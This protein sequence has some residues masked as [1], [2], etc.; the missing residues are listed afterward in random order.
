M[1]DLHFV[2]LIALMTLTTVVTRSFFFMLG[3]ARRMPGWLQKSLG[4]VPAVAL[5][6]ILA[7]DLLLSG[8]VL[9]EPWQNIRLLAAVAATAFFLATRHLLG[10]LVV[11]MVCYTALR[12]VF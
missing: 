5:S 2:L 10:T 7:P 11:G 4:Y 9:V 6:A 1:S 8:G 12:L 3:G